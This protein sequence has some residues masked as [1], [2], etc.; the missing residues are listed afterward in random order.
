MPKRTILQRLRIINPAL[1]WAM[2]G[3]S[4]SMLGNSA[5]EGSVLPSIIL[6]G[7]PAWVVAFRKTFGVVADFASPVS[8]WIVDKLGGF[9]ALALTEGVEGFLSLI[10]LLIPMSL[11]MWKWSLL[12]LSCALLLTGQVIDIA[13][14]VFEVDAAGGDE[15]MLVDYSGV[16]GIV[17]SVAGSLLGSPL[18][19]WMANWSIPIA[20][21]FSAITSFGAC[22]TRF[23]M[24]ADITA[25]MTSP[26]KTSEKNSDTDTHISD[27]A[28]D[29]DSN[30]DSD[31]DSVDSTSSSA[32]ASASPVTTRT[33]LGL[34]LGSLLVALVPS[35]ST[36]YIL[37]GMGNEYGPQ[38]L[39]VTAL[40]SGIADVLASFI[41]AHFASQLGM[42]KMA[43]IGVAVYAV[44]FA[45]LLVP[46]LPGIYTAYA[47]ASVGAILL[48]HPI[49]VSRQ[50]LFKGSELAQFSGHARFAYALGGTVGS[51]IGWMLSSS[52]RFLPILSLILILGFLLVLPQLP[53]TQKKK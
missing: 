41:Y 37:L 31:S 9:R 19:A 29:S 35:C 43:T 20:L 52:W 2:L 33:R 11:P 38:V 34:L 16:I 18:G 21:A 46:W 32:S 42:R 45:G 24:R 10:P 6:V 3:F 30:S 17:S 53:A 4:L 14:E 50:L 48:V 44:G 12:G 15:D 1:R 27:E 49:I 40:I 36:A 5:Y 47:V 25:S 28:A 23:A 26:E 39:T 22:A 13:S 7:L 8:A 51:W